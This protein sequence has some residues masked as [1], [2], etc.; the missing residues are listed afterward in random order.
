[1]IFA[2]I[3]ITAFSFRRGWM[4]SLIFVITLQ[5][6]LS[7]ADLWQDIWQTKD[8]QGQQV[9][10]QDPEK[11][12]ELFEDPNWKASSYYRAGDYQQA[13][14]NF[15][16]NTANSNSQQAQSHF[17]RGNALAHSG[18]LKQ[19]IKAY[20]QALTM[21]SELADAEFNK[22]LVEKL[23]QQQEQQDKDQNKQDDSNQQESDK[24]RL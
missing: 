4:L 6:E 21:D 13:A 22:E 24:K 20:E 18:E 17:N 2:I 8:Q 9:F 12:A 5:P 7:Y 14:K 16:A 11:A 19:A 10:E 23:L 1:L 15:S 3:L